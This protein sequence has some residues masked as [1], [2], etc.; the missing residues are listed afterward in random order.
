MQRCGWGLKTKKMAHQKRK[1]KESCNQKERGVKKC[2][3]G[4]DKRYLGVL[5]KKR[6]TEA[7]TRL[8]RR[9]E[10]W[11]GGGDGRFK[12]MVPVSREKCRSSVRPRL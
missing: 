5:R 8:I 9:K 1:V 11:G 10:G 7:E 2:V 12:E 4:K 3:K 6:L